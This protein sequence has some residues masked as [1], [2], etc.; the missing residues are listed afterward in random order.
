MVNGMTVNGLGEVSV[1]NDVTGVN[2][3]NS[4][5]LG[6]G[7]LTSELTH[8]LILGTQLLPSLSLFG[9]TL[10]LPLFFSFLPSN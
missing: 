6:L 10:L 1:M 4:S 7:K 3:S 9:F 8:Y 5:L 2:N